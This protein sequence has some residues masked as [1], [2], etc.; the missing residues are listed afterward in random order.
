MTAMSSDTIS[1][2]ITLVLILGPCLKTAAKLINLV[3]TFGISFQYFNS[4]YPSSAITFQHLLS[5][6]QIGMETCS[7]QHICLAPSRP[8]C[9]RTSGLMLCHI[10]PLGCP[11]HLMQPPCME[12]IDHTKNTHCKDLVI[13][14]VPRFLS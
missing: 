5:Q 4:S 6:S 12:C 2:S 1:F 14:T 9:A 8:H 11:P 13:R 3:L 10:V 7:G